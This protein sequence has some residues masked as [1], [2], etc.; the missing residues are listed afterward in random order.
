MT[1]FLIKNLIDLEQIVPYQ[2]ID[3]SYYLPNEQKIAFCDSEKLH[4]DDLFFDVDTI[5]DMHSEFGHMFPPKKI[6]LDY[7]MKNGINYGKNYIFYDHKGIFSAPRVF[8]TFL[9]YGFK[10]I[11]VLDGGYPAF[12]ALV[13]KPLATPE[14]QTHFNLINTLPDPNPLF[15]NSDYV[16]QALI[17]GSHKII[18]ARPIGRFCGTTPEPRAGLLSGHIPDSLNLPFTDLLTEQKTYKSTGEM[19]RIFNNLGVTHDDKIIF[20][21]GSGITACVVA[22]SALICGFKLD[23]IKIYDASW[24]EWGNGS[25]KVIQ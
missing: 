6:F 4:S 16:S 24:C 1:Q 19:M 2:Y 25:F 9:A 7:C 17:T 13:I 22:L 15:I 12:K 11:F 3:T 8:F 10:N 5:A 21:C 20:S 14:K 23:A 18:D